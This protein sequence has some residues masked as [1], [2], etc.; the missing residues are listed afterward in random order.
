MS[1]PENLEQNRIKRATY[2]LDVEARASPTCSSCGYSLLGL[3][4]L[5]ENKC[6]ECGTPLKESL[7]QSQSVHWKMGTVAQWLLW[8]QKGL[9]V[10]GCLAIAAAVGLVLLF[11]I[12]SPTTRTDVANQLSRLAIFASLASLA[13]GG[14]L[15]MGSL[16]A[17]RSFGVLR[18]ICLAILLLLFAPAFVV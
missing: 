18:D 8:L 9:L 6:P 14:L 1:R 4:S 11:P 12:W 17:R 7:S 15:L 5:S 13:C 2:G 16:V 3:T 10:S